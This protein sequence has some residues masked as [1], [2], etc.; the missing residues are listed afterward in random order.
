MPQ[1]SSNELPELDRHLEDLLRRASDLNRT[2]ESSPEQ[3][4]ESAETP[5]ASPAEQ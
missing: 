5:Q 3:Q 1:S 4:N 2:T